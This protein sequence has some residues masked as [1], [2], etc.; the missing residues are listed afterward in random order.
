VHSNENIL[1]ATEVPHTKSEML[2]GIDGIAIKNK[3][4]LTV[5]GGDTGTASAVYRKI[6][7]RT[8]YYIFRL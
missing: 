6:R 5:I 3:L 1:T 2:L 7:H 8:R 4:K